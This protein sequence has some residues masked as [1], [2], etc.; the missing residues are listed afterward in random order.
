[1]T[2]VAV[3]NKIVF[4]H[5]KCYLISLTDVVALVAA[6]T[7]REHFDTSVQPTSSRRHESSSLFLN[8][9]EYR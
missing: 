2:E 5:I 9:K 6:G 1:M 3:Y 8:N 7:F 4:Q